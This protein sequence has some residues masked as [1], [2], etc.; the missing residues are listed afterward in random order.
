MQFTKSWAVLSRTRSSGTCSVIFYEIT[1]GDLLQLD[2]DDDDEQH[3]GDEL[4][5]EAG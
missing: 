5:V 4:I 3:D 1:M 2:P